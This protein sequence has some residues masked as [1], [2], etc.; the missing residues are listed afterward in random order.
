M[1]LRLL[2]YRRWQTLFGFTVSAKIRP[3]AFHFK[4]TCYK[5][6]MLTRI[7][8]WLYTPHGLFLSGFIFMLLI[9]FITKNIRRYI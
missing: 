2:S 8:D 4:E 5:M 1:T 3:T 6:Q 7:F 9:L